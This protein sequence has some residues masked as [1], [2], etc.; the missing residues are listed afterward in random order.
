MPWPR[1]IVPGVLRTRSP[2]I[3]MIGVWISSIRRD[4]RMGDQSPTVDRTCQDRYSEG[5]QQSAGTL[6][7]RGPRDAL[8]VLLI[9]PSGAYNRKAPWG[10]PKGM[11]D[12]GEP[13][14]AAARRET[15][16]E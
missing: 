9:H 4:W 3:G 5:M 6:L 12:P 2:T 1:E 10:I 11:P 7:Y 16:E 15:R 14:E 8:E 13:L